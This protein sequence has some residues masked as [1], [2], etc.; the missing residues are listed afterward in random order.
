MNYGF[1]IDNSR[2]IGCHAC[3]TACKSENQVPLGVSRTWVKYVETGRYPDVTRHFQVTRC[4]HCANPPCVRICPTAAM[5]QRE[6]GIV[7]F[8]SDACIGCKACMQ[9]CPYDSIYIDPDTNTAAKCHFCAHRTD[10][11]LEPSCVVVCPEHAIIAGDLDDP[12]SEISR[13]VAKNQ[14]TVRKPEQGTAPNLFYI[15]GHDAGLHPTAA[16]ADESFLWADRKKEHHHFDVLAALDATHAENHDEQGLPV[17]GPLNMGGRMAEHMVQ[18]AYNHQHETPWHW[19]ISAYLITKHIAGGVFTLLGLAA[20]FGVFS[21]KAL[22][23]AGGFGLLNLLITLGL[24]VYDLERPDRFFYLLVR[25]QWRSWVARAAWILSAFGFVAGGWWVVEA[26][27]ALG[28]L[29]G[30][31]TVRPLFAALAIPTGVMASLY[32]AFLFAQAEGR[33]LWQSS[34]VIV[35]MIGQGAAL[36]AAPVMVV[37]IAWELPPTL[38]T[39]SRGLFVGGLG[40]SLVATI[41]GDLFL[42]H[43]SDIARRAAREL[44]RGKYRNYFLVGLLVGHLLPMALMLPGFAFFHLIAFTLA[45]AGL[46]VYAVAFVYAPQEVPNS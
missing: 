23:L 36:G 6:D 27:G 35:Q 13:L 19:P 42:P 18:V 11:G 24:L 16:D 38:L 29:G 9:A 2:C 8:E 21:T 41:A 40:L 1:L 25:P 30:V 15:D 37:G 20:L 3:S 26:L 10:V 39:V 31:E 14:V 28:W 44:T 46:F 22:L 33:D 45:A 4:N 17:G 7:Q 43:A 12:D 5:H 32:T 34:H